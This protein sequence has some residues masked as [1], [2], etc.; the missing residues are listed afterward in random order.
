MIDWWFIGGGEVDGCDELGC[1][2]AIRGV[3]ACL[4]VRI[5]VCCSMLISIGLLGV[6]IHTIQSFF[7]MS[8]FQHS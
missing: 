6:I 8:K 7:L 5:L 2:G 3:V 1:F 4:L